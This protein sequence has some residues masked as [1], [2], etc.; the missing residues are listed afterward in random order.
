[1][2]RVF[3]FPAGYAGPAIAVWAWIH[4]VLS[5]MLPSPPHQ[6]A[7]VALRHSV[8]G[9]APLSI[10]L[11]AFSASADLVAACLLSNVALY[12]LMAQTLKVD[13]QVLSAAQRRQLQSLSLIARVLNLAAI[14]IAAYQGARSAVWICSVSALICL[15]RSVREQSFFAHFYF[16]GLT[17]AAVVVAALKLPLPGQSRMLWVSLL[18][19]ALLVVYRWLM[20]LQG[21]RW[22][23]NAEGL[24]TLLWAIVLAA[25]AGVIE[26]VWGQLSAIVYLPVWIGFLIVMKGRLRGKSEAA[27]EQENRELRIAGYWVAH[28]AGAA[29]LI[30]ALRM[31][32]WPPAYASV[33]LAAWAWAHF[34]LFQTLSVQA[35]SRAVTPA[36]R[37]AVHGFALTAMSLAVYHVKEGPFP[38]VAAFLTGSLY[39]VLR[40]AWRQ[41]ALGDAAALAFIAAFSLI[42]IQW[43]IALPDYYLSLV[44]LYF[45]FILYRS[46][47]KKSISTGQRGAAGAGQAS[48]TTGR[49][50]FELDN[51]LTPA[52]VG[53][54]IVYPFWSLVGPLVIANQVFAGNLAPRR[55]PS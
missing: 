25:G 53:V 32:G 35:G 9:F 49:M 47:Q 44:G 2:L 8:H 24:L 52:I 3:G 12:F 16:L 18:A 36:T 10:L 50:R 37:H 29:L 7:T 11:A 48:E 54:L 55:L 13:G 22:A 39:L 4:Y 27:L 38:V 30:S 6:A 51:L 17:T 45:C 28:A 33:A 14:I 23:E 40:Q 15:W 34:G 1:M 31:L 41:E 26:G 42:G 43:Q 19:V 20:S 46:F 5:Q 21:R